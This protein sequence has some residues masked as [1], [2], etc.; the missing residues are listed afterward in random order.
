MVDNDV[1]QTY[2]PL[3]L[4]PCYSVS[5][6]T[7]ASEVHTSNNSLKRGG[8][9]YLPTDSLVRIV[10]AGNHTWMLRHGSSTTLP[11]SIASLQGMLSAIQ[12]Y[13]CT[14]YTIYCDNAGSCHSFRK[15]QS[16][17][18][19]TWT[20]LKALDNVGSGTMTLVYRGPEN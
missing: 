16:Q 7:D 19:Y 3:Y 2:E 14:S 13:G 6:F 4:F 11:G 5:V 9:V 8:G 17:C 20:I 10:W 15:G 12:Q 18:E 1:Q